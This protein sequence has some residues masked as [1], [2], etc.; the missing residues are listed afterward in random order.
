MYALCPVS[1]VVPPAQQVHLS[2]PTAADAADLL[3]QMSGDVTEEEKDVGEFDGGGDDVTYTDAEMEAAK[4]V[5]LR[6]TL[7]IH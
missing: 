4:Y 1:G 2:D 3:V 7:V 5:R 6:A